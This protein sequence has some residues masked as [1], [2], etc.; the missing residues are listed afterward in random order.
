MPHFQATLSDDTGETQTT[1]LQAQDAED[2]QRIL[3]E[4]GFDAT[5]IK[6]VIRPVPANPDQTPQGD[7]TGGLIPY[8]NPPAL[9]AYYLG[10]FSLFP[11]LGIGLAVPALILGLKGL[12]NS[13]EHPEVKGQVHAW[14]GIVMGGLMALIWGGLILLFIGLMFVGG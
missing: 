1:I 10:L 6:Q 5:D 13:K 3:A 4:R 2:A 7:A 11:V 12:R 9:T 8:K 14:I